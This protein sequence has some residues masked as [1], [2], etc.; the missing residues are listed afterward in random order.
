[1]NIK[2]CKTNTLLYTHVVLIFR[3]KSIISWKPRTIWPPSSVYRWDLATKTLETRKQNYKLSPGGKSKVVIITD[4]SNRT[5]LGSFWRWVVHR[6]RPGPQAPGFLLLNL[7]IF[8]N[9]STSGSQAP[10]FPLKSEIFGN[11]TSFTYFAGHGGK[12]TRA[13]E[14]PWLGVEQCEGLNICVIVVDFFIN[15]SIWS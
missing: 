9:W 5:W 15:D 2:E 8:E 1:M 12:T 3:L 10:G 4:G 11:P 14:R 6:D 7:N 13:T